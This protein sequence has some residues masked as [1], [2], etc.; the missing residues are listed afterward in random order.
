MRTADY[1]DGADKKRPFCRLRCQRNPRC[2]RFARLLCVLRVTPNK[3]LKEVTRATG[4]QYRSLSTSELRDF[5][6]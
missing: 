1:A 6:H 5:A 3:T 2:H 4:G